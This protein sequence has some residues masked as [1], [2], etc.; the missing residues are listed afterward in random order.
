MANTADGASWDESVPTLSD[1]RRDGQQEI[2]GLRVGLRKRLEKEHDTPSGSTSGGEHIA[3][4][5]KA[6]YQSGEPDKRPDEVNDPLGTG[7]TALTSDDNGR[8]W[9]NTNG[10]LRL[11]KDPDWIGVSGLNPSGNSNISTEIKETA[12]WTND[13]NVP[14]LV[15]FQGSSETQ[16]DLELDYGGGWIKFLDSTGISGTSHSLIMGSVILNPGDKIR[17]NPAPD[18]VGRGRYQKLI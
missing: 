17:F 6:Y 18:F 13:Q 9:S 4:S 16:F 2:R 12:G 8:L 5:A 10:V 11:Y 14:V 15:C 3:G 7:G 1:P